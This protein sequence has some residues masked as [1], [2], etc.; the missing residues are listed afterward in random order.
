MPEFLEGFEDLF[1]VFLELFLAFLEFDFSVLA[2]LRLLGFF[3][4]RRRRGIF[5]CNPSGPF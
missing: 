3:F 5:P 1:A 4:G 2:V